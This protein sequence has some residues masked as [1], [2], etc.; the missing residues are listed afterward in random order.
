MVKKHATQTGEVIALPMLALAAL[1]AVKADSAVLAEQDGRTGTVR[2]Q[3]FI[4]GVTA[5]E[6]DT[7][8]YGICQSYLSNAEIAAILVQAPRRDRDTAI[9]D[10]YARLIGPVMSPDN[11]QPLATITT[12]NFDSGWLKL[13]ME[14]MEEDPIFSMFLFNYSSGALT[15]GATARMF[16]QSVLSWKGD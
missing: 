13:N 6:M 11:G 8:L 3:G 16:C 4:I 14:F 9:R 1:A 2:A 12:V 7:I 10:G 15:T 5:G